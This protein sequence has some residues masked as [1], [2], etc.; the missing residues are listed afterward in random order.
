[1]A[2]LGVREAAKALGLKVVDYI[3]LERG[4][5]PITEVLLDRIAALYDVPAQVLTS[6]VPL[7][8][9]RSFAP[10]RYAEDEAVELA[11]LYRETL[12]ALYRLKEGANP[13]AL[14]EVWLPPLPFPY[15]TLTV[16]VVPTTILLELSHE[17]RAIGGTA[18]ISS[19]EATYIIGVNTPR[20]SVLLKPGRYT[21]S[22][23][24][25]VAKLR[26]SVVQC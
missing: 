26:F 7:P 12:E 20:R 4:G 22:A 10:L 23:T 25:E 18:R 14:K 8:P 11:L 3:A 16:G 2:G 9:P 17:V 19:R 1:M 24:L 13:R 15:P 5:Y 21:I 6:D